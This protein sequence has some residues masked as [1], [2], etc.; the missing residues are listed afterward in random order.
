MTGTLY[1]TCHGGALKTKS[2][3]SLFQSGHNDIPIKQSRSQLITGVACGGKQIPRH[4]RGSARRHPALRK[5]HCGASVCFRPACS[6]YLPEKVDGM[7]ERGRSREMRRRG[8]QKLVYMIALQEVCRG[9]RGQGS[10]APGVTLCDYEVQ[11][12]CKRNIYSVFCLA[13]KAHYKIVMSI[14]LSRCRGLQRRHNMGREIIS[15][16][17]I[18]TL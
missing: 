3:G 16:G 15:A 11:N 18:L 2:G 10:R 17:V 6:S 4:E 14:Q 7:K 8:G 5:K 9:S 13:L 12:S 1:F